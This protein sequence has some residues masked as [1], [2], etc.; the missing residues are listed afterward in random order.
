MRTLYEHESYLDYLTERLGAA[1]TRTGLRKKAAEAIGCHPTQLSQIMTGR[2]HLN[3]EQAEAMNLF[4]GHDDTEAEY[5]IALVDLARAGTPAL[6]S[7]LQ[8]RVRQF[9]ASRQK[10]SAR[11]MTSESIP[12]EKK[13]EFYRTWLYAAIHVLVTVP[14]Y[15]STRA[16]A[17]RLRIR[18]SRIANAVQFLVE[19]GLLQSIDGEYRVGTNFVHLDQSAPEIYQHH[20]NWRLRTMEGFEQPHPEDLH[21]SGTLTVSRADVEAIRQV[22]LDTVSRVSGVVKK[23]QPEEAYVLGLDFFRL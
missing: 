20:R 18:E 6:R 16:L 13:H 10:I 7:R 9:Q 17:K 3:A 15:R 5:F 22:V 11:V 12:V 8:A 1:G 21:Y 4:L 2:I 23:T 19:I 14:E